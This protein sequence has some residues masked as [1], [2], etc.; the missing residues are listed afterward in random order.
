MRC[1]ASWLTRNMPPSN[2]ENNI[3]TQTVTLYTSTNGDA[4]QK[5][6]TVDNVQGMTPSD[7]HIGVLRL[8]KGG[9]QLQGKTGLY[10]TNM[11]IE[12]GPPLGL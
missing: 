6:V 11:W 1:H 8:P 7:L 3:L 2:I 5:R 9:K 10:Y 4:L 12:S